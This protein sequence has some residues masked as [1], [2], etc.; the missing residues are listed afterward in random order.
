MEK[1]VEVYGESEYDEVPKKVILDIDI[2]VRS[3]KRESAQEESKDIVNK[4][5]DQ[6]LVKGL[7]E[8]EIAFGGR[9][10]LTPWQ[11]KPNEHGSN[12]R[13]ARKNDDYLLQRTCTNFHRCRLDPA[14]VPLP[15]RPGAADQR[16]LPAQ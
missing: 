5:I 9:E 2:S 7:K 10:T 11:K 8:S 3:A 13:N 12:A 15:R 1:F 4:A 14:Q 16:Q 6:L